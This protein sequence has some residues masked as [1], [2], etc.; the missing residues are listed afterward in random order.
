LPFRHSRLE[1]KSHSLLSGIILKLLFVPKEDKRGPVLAILKMKN[2]IDEV[3][4]SANKIDK[5]A[6]SKSRLGCAEDLSLERQIKF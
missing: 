4:I 5:E 1:Q 3:M 2:G 6:R